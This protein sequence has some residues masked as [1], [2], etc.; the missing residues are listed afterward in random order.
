MIGT[1]AANFT[2]YSFSM[3]NNIEKVINIFGESDYI[4]KEN[5]DK[6]Y[7]YFGTKEAISA[8]RYDFLEITD[9]EKNDT[10]YL[11]VREGAHN[12]FLGKF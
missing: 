1:L 12:Q 7:E 6:L 11:D 4:E 8:F 10:L 5:I 3:F 2:N 9:E